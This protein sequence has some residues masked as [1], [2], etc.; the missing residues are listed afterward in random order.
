[1]LFLM[2][3]A[4]KQFFPFVDVK[5]PKL[6]RRYREW[7]S[8]SNYAPESYR[9]ETSAR[10]AALRK[11]YKLGSRPIEEARS[12]REGGQLSLG[13]DW[14]PAADRSHPAACAAQS[15]LRVLAP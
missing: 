5:F 3:S 15:P 10:V 13:L 11:K 4:Q 8:R 6:A 2:P 7:Y 1:V 14:G 9:R 12:G